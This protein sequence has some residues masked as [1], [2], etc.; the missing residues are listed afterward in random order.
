M[1]NLLMHR[2]TRRLSGLG[3]ERASIV[4]PA[5]QCIADGLCDRSRGVETE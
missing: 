4:Q 5:L 3:E 1:L 2:V